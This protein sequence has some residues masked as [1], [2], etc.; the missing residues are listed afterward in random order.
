MYSTGWANSVLP[1]IW[2]PKNGAV[3]PLAPLAAFRDIAKLRPL[4]H[5]QQ[6]TGRWLLGIAIALRVGCCGGAIAAW[7]G[8]GGGGAANS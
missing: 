7:G 4:H 5:C 1:R 2:C 3:K 8:E 6:V